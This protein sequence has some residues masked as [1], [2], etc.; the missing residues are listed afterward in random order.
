MQVPCTVDPVDSLL[1]PERKV[2]AAL[3]WLSLMAIA[4]GSVSLDTLRGKDPTQELV[5]HAPLLAIY[6]VG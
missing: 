4:G 3:R 1:P 2:L 6:Q 5:W